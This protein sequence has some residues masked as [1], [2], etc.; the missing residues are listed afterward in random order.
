MVDSKL[1]SYIYK[2]GILSTFAVCMSVGVDF[3]PP[4]LI[5][6]RQWMKVEL[7][8]GAPPRTEFLCHPSG[9]MQAG[10]FS[11][12]FD[13]F[14]KYAKPSKEDPVLLILDGHTTYTNNLDFIEKARNNHNTVVCVPLHCSHKLQPLDVSFI[15]PF[16]T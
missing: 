9:W 8:D 13:H 3:F 5:L 11:Q 10:I 15:R 12:W 16:N 14:L 4:L 6:P 2:K 1:V 7:K